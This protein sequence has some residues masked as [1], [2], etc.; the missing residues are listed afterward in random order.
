MSGIDSNDMKIKSYQVRYNT[1]QNALIALR[2]DPEEMEWRE[3]KD[4]DI[5]CLEDPEQDAKREMWA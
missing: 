3:V 4:I 5:R 2:E 1:A